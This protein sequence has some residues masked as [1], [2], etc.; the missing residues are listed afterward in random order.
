MDIKSNL[1]IGVRISIGNY[2]NTV[3]IIKTSGS[4]K[5]NK[6]LVMNGIMRKINKVKLIIISWIDSYTSG[7]F[8]N[9][10]FAKRI[11]FSSKIL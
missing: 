4:G 8:N 11:Y 1:N 3:V 5:R 7:S 6:Q 9:I 2:I 10:V